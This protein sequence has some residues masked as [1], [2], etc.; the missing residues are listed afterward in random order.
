MH[1][2]WIIGIGGMLMVIGM[3]LILALGLGH[4]TMLNVIEP[5]VCE[6]GEELTY[7][8]A[9]LYMPLSG[10]PEEGV[11]YECRGN[12]TL[13]D[14]T[15]QVGIVQTF[16]L[17]LTGLGLLMATVTPVLWLFGVFKPRPK[18]RQIEDESLPDDIVPF[19]ALD[20]STLR[21]RLVPDDGV[22]SPNAI[23]EKTRIFKILL[24][25]GVINMAQYD[26]L[27]DKL[28]EQQE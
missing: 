13:Y 26:E 19:A 24:Q 23:K 27:I 8:W 25:Y 2:Q 5:F 14:V 17:V 16:F 15:D 21:Q 22:F 18:R 28:L 12:N 10:E 6:S 9:Y 4:A 7:R 11:I 1:P 20:Y 3:I